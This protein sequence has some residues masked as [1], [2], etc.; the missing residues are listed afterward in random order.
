MQDGKAA[1]VVHREV[2]VVAASTPYPLT[3]RLDFLAAA[4]TLVVIAA[5]IAFIPMM[6]VGVSPSAWFTTA[7][8]TGKSASTTIVDAQLAHADEVIE[9]LKAAKFLK[10]VSTPARKPHEIAAH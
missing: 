3:Y 6:I 4:G 8:K 1:A 10:D 2:P 7:A 5:L 9:A